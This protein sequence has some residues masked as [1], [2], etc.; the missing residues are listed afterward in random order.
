MPKPVLATVTVA[1]DPGKDP[2]RMRVKRRSDRLMNYFLLVYFFGGFICAAFYNTWIA[3]LVTGSISLFIYY[4]VKKFLPES[5]LYQYILSGIM[6]V[7]MAQYIYQMHGM[8]EIYFFAFVGSTILITYQNWKL[9]I[10]LFSIVII[11]LAI[12]GYHQ[13]PGVD[14]PYLTQLS[15]FELE[16]FILHILLAGLV[17]FICGLWGYL[18]KKYSDIQVLQTKEMER[19]QMEALLAVKEQAVIESNSRFNYAAQ[20]T[21]D[22]IWDRN[23]SNDAIF[24]GDGYRAL[25]GYDITPETSS[26]NFWASKVH[27]EDFQTITAT[28]R[29]A[30]DDPGVRSWSCEYRFL[31]ANGE[32]AFVREKAIILRD[33]SGVPS[34]T[35]G[36]LQ[37]ISEMKQSELTLKKLNDSLEKEKYY[38][39]SLM[40]NMPVAIYFKDRESKFMR[41][42]KYM[43]SKHLAEHPGAT[44]NDLIGKSDFDFQ[45]KKHALEAYQDEQEIQ[46]TR[47]PKIDYIEK[48]TKKDGSERWVRTTKLPLINLQGEVV[49][50]FGISRDITKLKMLEKEQYEANLDKAVAQGKFEI[51]SDVMH[52][53]G[54]A[55]VGFGS[56]LTRLRRMQEEDSPA[57]NLRNLAI[58]FEEN[59]KAIATTFGEAKAGALIKMLDTMALTQS[60]NQEETG[61]VITEQLNIIANIQEIL[62]IQRQ[63]ITGHE[64]KER[65]PVKLATIINDSLAML[66]TSIDK[67]G[68]AV[69][70]NV[71]ADL[72]TIKGDRT[73]LIQVILNLLKNSIEAIDIKSPE[74][75]ICIKAY[76]EP[77]RLLLQV[78][79]SGEGFDKNVS[80]QIFKKKFTTK[81]SGAGIGL[82]N[83][84]TIMESHEGSLEI[85]SEGQGKGALA[86]IGFKM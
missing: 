34:R 27:P 23:Y 30:K 2:F 53:I 71:P 24:W 49:G 9:Q 13:G 31:K 18:L 41:V 84:R 4:L 7:F 22:A 28:I 55:V 5:N 11:H 29:E 50:T 65:K 83:C 54:N 57:E 10:P 6:G 61:K 42:S 63:Y 38:L 70:L 67:M 1:Q 32:Y 51:A 40:D 46:L 45:D 16:R 33:V 3:A 47:I 79:D 74:K 48:E 17:F 76:T 66:F 80:G 78:R 36:A 73:K 43:V 8:F 39:D 77:G 56:Y 59:K 20:A 15:P 60:N 35:I 12:F 64:S 37:D 19:L 62:N 26:I 82:Y 52:D 25:F 14:N 75:N 86:T 21:S 68:I 44:V 81:S 69:S 72:P 58:F 85:S